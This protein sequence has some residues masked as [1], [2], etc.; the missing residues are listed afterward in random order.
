MSLQVTPVRENLMLFV[1][2]GDILIA[3]AQ[4]QVVLP[5]VDTPIREAALQIHRRYLALTVLLLSSAANP[6]L[7]EAI[8]IARGTAMRA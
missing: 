6:L 8:L 4:V 5:R 3:Q 2:Q 1:W 7:G